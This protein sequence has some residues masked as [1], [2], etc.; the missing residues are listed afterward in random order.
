M[1]IN[2]QKN[3]KILA[4]IVYLFLIAFFCYTAVNKLMNLE[5]FRINLMKTSLF[6]EAIAKY[7]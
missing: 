7:F 6:S 4:E 5:S 1:I 3:N 2:Y